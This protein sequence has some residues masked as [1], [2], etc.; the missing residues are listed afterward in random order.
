VLDVGGTRYLIAA[1]SAADATPADRAVLQGVI[2]S[3]A[4]AS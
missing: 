1:L 3:I 4:L 2:D